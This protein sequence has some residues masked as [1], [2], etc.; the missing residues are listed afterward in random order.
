MD[1]N[2]HF[3]RCELLET[4]ALKRKGVTVLEFDIVLI[5]NKQHA[6]ISVTQGDGFKTPI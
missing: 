6:Q 4:K 3:E 2:L 1:D 5:R